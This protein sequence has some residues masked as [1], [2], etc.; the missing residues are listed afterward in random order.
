MPELIP[1][2]VLL[3]YLLPSLVAALRNHDMLVPILIA[4][5][6]LGWTVVGWFLILVAAMFAPVDGEP[7]GRRS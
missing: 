1:F 7:A 4:N 2:T 6:A 3:L 5:V